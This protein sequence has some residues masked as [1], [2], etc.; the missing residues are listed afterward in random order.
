[1]KKLSEKSRKLLRKVYRILGVT[2]V[3]LIIQACYGMPMVYEEPPAYGMPPDTGDDT[4]L[5]EGDDTDAKDA[6]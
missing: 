4:T 2:T 3:A 5:T 6:E 1:M